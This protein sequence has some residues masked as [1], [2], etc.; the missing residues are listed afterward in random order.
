MRIAVVDNLP[1]GGAKRVVYEQVKGLAKKHEVKLWTNEDISR[2]DYNKLSIPI[3][4]VSLKVQEYEGLL[5]PLRE[6]EIY[7]RLRKQ[8]VL[9]AKEITEFKAEVV[10]VHPDK[11]TQAPWLLELTDLPTLYFAEEW[12]RLVYEP[13]WHQ[14]KKQSLYKRVYESW[15]RTYLKTIDRYLTRKARTVLTTSNINAANFKA[16]YQLDTQILLLGVD[17]NNFKPSET[18]DEKREYF[19]FIGEK[20]EFHGYDLLG[21][22]IQIAP[23]EMH[24]KVISM[25]QNQYQYS[26]Q[27]LAI[28]YQ[29]AA[30]V[31]CFDHDEPFGLVP[32][33]AMACGT[34]VI[35]V[36]EGGY[37]DTIDDGVTGYL[38]PRDEVVIYKIMKDL[39]NEPLRLRQMGVAGRRRVLEYYRWDTHVAKLTDFLEKLAHD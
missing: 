26:D 25:T 8:Y 37:K 27:E 30:A 38:V 10:V 16:A 13:R 19:L 18:E 35:A 6:W 24:I 20:D 7:Y 34:P 32:L 22:I 39:A 17:I 33:E 3:N 1:E 11:Y 5:R 12:L 14:Y 4:R 36:N 9:I 23:A 31:L 15:R 2:F 29:K 21:K 28:I